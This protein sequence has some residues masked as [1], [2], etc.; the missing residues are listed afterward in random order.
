MPVYLFL[1]VEATLFIGEAV[2]STKIT[3]RLGFLIEPRKNGPMI[4]QKND[5]LRNGFFV[6]GQAGVFDEINYE[7]ASYNNQILPCRWYNKQEPFEFE[8]VVNGDEVGMHKIF[9]DLQIISN[10]VEPS[11]FEY[12]I[13][14]DVY[15]FNKRGIFRSKAF[16]EDEFAALKEKQYD[17]AT[18]YKVSQD[19]RNADITWNT[20]TNEYSIRLKQPTLNIKKDGRVAGN[21]HYKEGI[22]YTTIDPIKF[23]KK[24]LIDNQEVKVGD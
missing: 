9:N 5:L 22:W 16:G 15:E 6:H 11:E 21:I 20:T 13:V 2:V 1:D 18:Q 19:F 17:Q 12:E 10:N 24:Y 14:G 23:R 7:D 4:L 8:F 3:D